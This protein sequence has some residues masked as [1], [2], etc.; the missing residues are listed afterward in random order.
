MGAVRWCNAA[1]KPPPLLRHSFRLHL[2]KEMVT[3]T[4]SDYDSMLLECVQRWAPYTELPLRS[5]RLAFLP[6]RLGGLSLHSWHDTADAA[7]VAGYC[8]AATFL[9]QIHDWNKDTFPSLLFSL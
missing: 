6:A 3:L 5:R 7:S 2:K 9:R 8:H 4:A 1:M